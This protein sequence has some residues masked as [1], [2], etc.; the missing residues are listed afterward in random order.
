MQ[1]FVY[2]Y[3]TK[4]YFGAGAAKEHLAS[5][6]FQYGTNVMLAYGGGSVKKNGIYDEIKFILEGAGKKV[7][8]FSG[9]MSNPTYEKIQEGAELV[10]ENQ[11][12]HGRCSS[13]FCHPSPGIYPIGTADAGDLRSF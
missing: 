8:D 12:R 11:D 4:V 2:E 3:P 10:K 13:P 7:F 6:V 9:I 5:A 1:K